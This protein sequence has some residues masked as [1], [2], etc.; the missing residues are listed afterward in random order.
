MN[1]L[2]LKLYL[3]RNNHRHR[4][5]L[6]AA[7]LESSLAEDDLRVLVIMKLTM[8]QQCAFRAKA[9]LECVLPAG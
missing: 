5:L 6:G 4:Y 3:G 7:Q 9:A 1:V 2:R 8:S